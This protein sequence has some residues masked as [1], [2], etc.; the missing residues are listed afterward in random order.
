MHFDDS[1]AEAE[2]RA[3]VRAWLDRHAKLRSESEHTLSPLGAFR[4]DEGAI[5][6]ARAW[7]AQ[8][9]EARLAAIHWPAEHGGRDASPLESMVRAEELARYDVPGEVFSI[10]I[11]MIG[12]TIIAHGTDEQKARF[13]RPMLR[14]EEIWCQLWSEPDAGSDLAGLT[15]R[16]VL[17]GD[18]YVVDGQ[19]VWTS[20]AH[21]SDW[22]LGIFRTN[23]E[24]PK[25]KGITCMIVDMS[26]PGI[27]VRPLRQMTGGA[28]FNEVFFDG[29]RV[30]AANVVGDVDDGWRVAR[31][32]L[33]NERYA[34]GAMDAS[35]GAFAALVGVAR[36]ASADG[37]P[38]SADPK[39]RQELARIYTLGRLTELTSARVRTNLARAMIPGIEGSI[40]KLALAELVTER[41]DLGLRLLGASGGLH[42]G[43][44]PE[45]GRWAAALVGSFAV[46]IGGGTDQVQ[47]NIIGERVLGLPREPSTDGEVPFKDVRVGTQR[48]PSPS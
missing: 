7:Q 46:H 37:R 22:G 16:A 44:A 42:G 34:A 13:L 28:H 6:E 14:G 43:D 24:M 11:A 32:T 36:R 47:R 5:A 30:P 12:P 3:E 35:D 10:G 1:P 48:H 9:A 17:D 23:P 39:M 20:G 15:T 26:T 25:H 41:A 29:A 8:L 31:T 21:Y 4:D 33:M 27:T 18:E 2:F 19:K 45:G 38:G 40:L